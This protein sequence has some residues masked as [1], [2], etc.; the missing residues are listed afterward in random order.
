MPLI[1]FSDDPSRAAGLKG[2]KGFRLHAPGLP[3]WRRYLLIGLVATDAD[4]G[5]ALTMIRKSPVSR[6]GVKAGLFLPPQ[7]AGH[8]SG[9]AGHKGLNSRALPGTHWRSRESR[10]GTGGLVSSHAAGRIT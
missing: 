5:S 9:Q 7:H 1:A 3:E 4:L 8:F 2:G 6:W 10:E